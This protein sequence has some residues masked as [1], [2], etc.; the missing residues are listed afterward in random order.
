MERLARAGRRAASSRATAGTSP[1]ASARRRRADA[2]DGDGRLRRPLATGASSSSATAEALA[3]AR[4]D[5]RRR[6]AARR[7]LVVPGHARARARARRAAAAAES[8][9]RSTRSSTRRRSHVRARRADADRPGC[10]E[11][12]ARFCAIDVRPE[13]RAGRELPPRVGRPDARLPARRGRDRLLVLV[14]WALG[15]YLWEVVADAAEHSAAA[16]SAPTRSDATPA[17]LRCVSSSARGGCG[18]RARRAARQLRRRDR[19]RRR[20]RARDRVLPRAARRQE[21]RGAR[22]ELHRLRR[23]RAQHDDPALE[24]QDARGRALLRREREDVR[25]AVAPSSTSTCCSRSAA[26]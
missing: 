22:E 8:A 17:E 10:R 25:A 13:G 14:G 21:R 2:A 9:L 11:L 6:R 15:E 5:A 3:G 16:R 23:R 24:L 20:A 4:A 18:A 7:R 26:T 19:R 12:L 1:P